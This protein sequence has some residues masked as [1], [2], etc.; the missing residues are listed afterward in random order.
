MLS[1]LLSAFCFL[2]TVAIYF[3]SKRI[4]R[5]LGTW[6]STP[7]VLSPLALIFM[8]VVARIPFPVYFRDTRWLL[9][10]LGPATV[11]FGVPIYENRGLIRSQALPLIS[12]VVC[13]VILG[14]LTSA[15]LAHLFRLNTVLTQSL[16]TRSISTPFALAA[17][18]TMGGNPDLAGLFVILTG[19]AGMVLGDA[20]LMLPALRSALAKGAMLGGAAHAVGSARALQEGTEEGAT[21][22]LTMILAGI[23]LVLLAPL[24]RR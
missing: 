20:V 7:L 18:P 14:L 10:L 4:Y 8:V 2:A 17:A 23:T 9:W 24:L 13:S 11:A 22:S 19:V 3:L 6:W 12:G 5:R 15:G 1:G 16:M 21:A